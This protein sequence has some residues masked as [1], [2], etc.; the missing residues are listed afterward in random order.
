MRLQCE[1]RENLYSRE[2]GR[3]PFKW[4]I[5]RVWMG[6]IPTLNTYTQR[7][8]NLHLQMRVRTSPKNQAQAGPP[9][10]TKGWGVHLPPAAPTLVLPQ[11]PPWTTHTHQRRHQSR[12]MSSHSPG[13]REGGPWLMDASLRLAETGSGPSGSHHEE[14]TPIKLK[15]KRQLK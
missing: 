9:A 4:R 13:Y 14:E 10:S 6:Q 15:L 11:P 7:F 1:N 12:H 5:P 3:R 2:R 8:L